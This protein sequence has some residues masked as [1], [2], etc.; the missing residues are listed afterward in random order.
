MLR[1]RPL[2]PHGLW[3][4]QQVPT[5]PLPSPGRD[6]TPAYSAPYRFA[7]RPDGSLRQIR[8]RGLI[9]VI[10]SLIP[11]VT[12]PAAEAPRPLA[13]P[14]SADPTPALPGEGP[15]AGLFRS[16]PFRAS[17]GWLAPANPNAGFNYRYYVFISC[18]T[19]PAA[20]APRPS[21]VPYRP[22]ARNGEAAIRA[23][24]SATRRS[25][26]MRG[27]L[28]FP[29]RRIHLRKLPGAITLS[30]SLSRVVRRLAS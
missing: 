14:A 5:P 30:E 12:V 9:I 4:C 22:S 27:T 8:T 2:K 20:E 11:Y 19:V 3:P 17:S 29:V 6:R 21:A 10:T 16:V 28:F 7:H 1:F 15:D 13:V 26:A 23:I 25:P 18:V 24:S